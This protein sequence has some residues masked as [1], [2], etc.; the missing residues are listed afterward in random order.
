MPESVVHFQV[1]MPPAL[2]E[3]LSSRAMDEKASLNALIVE[4]LREAME[5]SGEAERAKEA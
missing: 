5:R 3:K 1:R 4:I 2:H